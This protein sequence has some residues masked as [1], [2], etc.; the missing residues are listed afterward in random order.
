[1]VCLERLESVRI[2]YQNYVK[3]C[4]FSSF[5]LTTELPSKM[6]MDKTAKYL[7]F[8]ESHFNCVSFDA[9]F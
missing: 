8:E 9:E 5:Y 7:I 4:L 3:S 2:E 1:M 6:N